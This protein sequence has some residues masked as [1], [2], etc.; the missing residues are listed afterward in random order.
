MQRLL[1]TL[2]L[3]GLVSAA[4]CNGDTTNPLGRIPGGTGGLPGLG[5][6]GGA[7]TVTVGND[8]FDPDSVSVPVNGT[9]T[10][11]WAA[12]DSLHTVTFDDAAPGS[13][14]QSSGTFSRTFTAVG[15]YTYF[16]SIHGRAVMSGQVVVQ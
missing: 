16:C 11:T 8:F 15:T 13:P 5:G 12:G 9:V 4:A 7:V 14:P 6:G 1:A 2:A 10:W 3:A